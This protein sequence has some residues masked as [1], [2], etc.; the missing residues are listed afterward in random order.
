M[1]WARINAPPKRVVPKV[2]K[3][4]IVDEP[5]PYQGRAP[6][7]KK[8]SI[9]HIYCVND[10]YVTVN[11]AS[12]NSHY[13]GPD[14]VF[15]RPKKEEVKEYYKKIDRFS[16]GK[17][18]GTFGNDPEVFVTDVSGVVIPA[19]IFLPS[20]DKGIWEGYK[21]SVDISNYET[22]KEKQNSGRRIFWDGFQAEFTSPPH[23]CFG[24]GCDYIRYGLCSV[25]REARKFDPNAKLSWKSV[26]DAPLELIAGGPPDGIALGCS[27]SKNA[28]T[29]EVNPRLLQLDPT[30]LDIRFAGYHIHIGIPQKAEEAYKGIIKTLDAI[31]GVASVALFEG[32]EDVRRRQYY[33]LAGEYRTPR[34]GLEWRVLSSC[35]LCHP[36]IFHLLSDL[37]R[38]SAAFYAA[39]ISH[40]WESGEDQ[41]Q[42]IINN[43]N[44]EEARKL[45]KS[46]ESVLLAL[47]RGPYSAENALKAIKAIHA[48]VRNV[49]PLDMHANWKIDKEWKDHSD[50]LSVS[51][52]QTYLQPK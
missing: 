47:L 14:S 51:W 42:D 23:T 37:T 30:K 8:G 36:A 38:A 18:S 16:F 2:G 52:Q 3:L 31:A 41:V 1:I 43:L 49:L 20:K 11:D 4:L 9:Y 48:G 39:K 34:H 5:A 10:K 29:D 32:M 44:V 33:G 17:G 21:P 24:Y 26:I 40:L 25:L 13:M 19:Y 22:E 46:N 15:R 50:N 27:P 45:L 7:V 6:N 35:V 28:Y 12:M